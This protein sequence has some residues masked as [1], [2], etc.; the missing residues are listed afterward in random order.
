M[1]RLQKIPGRLRQKEGYSLVEL[2]VAVTIVTFTIIA[3]VAMLRKGSEITIT[4]N[5]RERARAIVDSSF[6]SPWC[7]FSNYAAIATVSNRAVLID[8]RDTANASD[9]LT[10][11]LAVTVVLDS[12]N[13]AGPGVGNWVVFKRVTISV[14]WQE[15]EG[16]QTIALEKWITGLNQ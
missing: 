4:G 9:N 8:A 11:T 14:S 7:H 5:H 16:Q 3:L 6:E 13:A 15:P 12:N 2:L 1:I 10:G